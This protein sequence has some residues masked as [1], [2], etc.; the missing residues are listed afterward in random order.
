[1]NCGNKGLWQAIN[2]DQQRQP[3]HVILTTEMG[4][5]D[6]TWCRVIVKDFARGG[7]IGQVCAGSVTL[8]SSAG[9]AHRD[10]VVIET[11]R[12]FLHRYVQVS[13]HEGED[14]NPTIVLCHHDHCQ[15]EH[16]ERVLMCRPS[17]TLERA[18][19]VTFSVTRFDGGMSE[20]QQADFFRDWIHP[21]M[22]CRLHPISIGERFTFGPVSFTV[23]F[24]DPWPAAIFGPGT[25]IE[26][27]IASKVELCPRNNDLITAPE[28]L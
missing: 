26:A 27:V 14:G 19:S 15:L 11:H 7:F 2:N 12:C 8:P 20:K 5:D 16:P 10:V 21:T 28:P 13:D 24:I 6:G 25:H 9:F 17:R 4:N 22:D 3:C 18:V 1:M 23:F